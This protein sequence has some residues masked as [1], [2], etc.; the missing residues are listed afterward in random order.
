M[1]C[2]Y[3]TEDGMN[4]RN[5]FPKDHFF[6]GE[7]ENGKRYPYGVYK[8]E[9]TYSKE[10]AD[11]KFATKEELADVAEHTAQFVEDLEKSKADKTETADIVRRLEAL[12]YKDIK[13]NSFTAAPS[14]AE[15]G[16]SV[17]VNLTW[18]LNKAAAAT[19]IN[20][21]EVT[22]T[23]K[24]FQNVTT[25]TAYVLSVNDGKTSDSKSASI[26]FANNIY[27]GAAKDL[28]SVAS[29]TKVLS[30]N[31]ARTITV[32]AGTDEYII[33][34]IP[35]RLGTVLFY[36]SGF[37]GGFEEPVAMNIANASGYSESYNVY[38]STRSS[39]GNT[40][41]EIKKG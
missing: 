20:G 2:P 12:E 8:K 23:S 4:D 15:R 1:N 22:G 16:S 24:Q 14:V 30:E 9:E 25:T 40:T 10:E 7:I 39:L 38:R 3:Q 27:Y 26:T 6:I 21:A 18:N 41:I 13:I 29:L 33:Y 36:V 34:A 28:E 5:R 37:E 31:T 19:Y 11:G 17:N 32:D 35:A